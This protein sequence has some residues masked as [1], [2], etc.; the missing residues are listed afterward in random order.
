[1]KEI[2][3]ALDTLARNISTVIIGKD[4]AIRLVLAAL[5][6]RGHVLLEDMPGVGKTMLARALAR[7]VDCTFK[8]IQCTPDLLPVDV[9]GYVDPRTRE[10]RQGPVFGHIVLADEL[11]R[12]TPRTQSALLEAMGEG[13]VSIEGET[14][15]LPDPFMVIATQ[16]PVEHRGVND[17]P[18]AQ[19][20]RFQMLLSPGYP[21]EAEEK[22][23]LLA[24]ATTDPIQS[25]Q[26]VM[27]A[28]TLRGIMAKVPEVKLAE[29]LIDYILALVRATRGDEALQIGASPRSGLQL[30]H[31]ARAYALVQG[32][33]YVIPDDIKLLAQHVLPHRVFPASTSQETLSTT[34]WKQ[35]IVRRIIATVKVPGI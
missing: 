26:P 31:L 12:A 28:A 33:A 7:S 23:I 24:R 6:S 5:L 30:M 15:Q 8:R 20:D 3:S 14:H 25:L 10:F 18:E 35:E 21:D 29:S 4:D 11:N 1:M 9:T 19:L 27:N 16:N 17:L 34:A 2:H 13:Q 22:R 32:R